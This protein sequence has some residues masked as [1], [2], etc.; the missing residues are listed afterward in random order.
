ME[1]YITGSCHCESVKIQIPFDGEFNKLRRCD[2]SLCAKKWAVVA[3]VPVASLK[4]IQGADKLTLYQW[5][6]KVAKHYFCSICG[7]YTHH[8]RRSDPREFGINIACFPQVNV[9][10]YQG[11]PYVDGRNHPRDLSV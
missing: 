1:G 5:N 2:C 3:S 4:V 7:I 8:Q 10:D 6:T 11:I 9:R